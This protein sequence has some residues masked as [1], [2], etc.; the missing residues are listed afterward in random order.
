MK[1]G[2]ASP[3]YTTENKLLKCIWSTGKSI[4]ESGAIYF[5]HTHDRAP[6]QAKATQLPFRTPGWAG[7]ISD[8]S[9]S[10]GGRKEHKDSPS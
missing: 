3:S 1:N 5:H 2:A 8:V 9:S 10:E 7:H 6:K 4:N